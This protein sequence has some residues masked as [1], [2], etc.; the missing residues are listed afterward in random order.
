MIFWTHF[1]DLLAKIAALLVTVLLAIGV[2]S[3]FG[4]SPQIFAVGCALSALVIGIPLYIF[5]FRTLG[6]MIYC[7]QRLKA[8][9]TFDQAKQ[10]NFALA[11]AAQL[12]WCPLL[13]VRD[14]EVHQKFPEAL[15]LA[16][17][18]QQ[19]RKLFQTD[20]AEILSEQTGT[21]KLVR[22]TMLAIATVGFG[23]GYFAFPPTDRLAAFQASFGD[24]GKYSPMLNG[25]LV[26]ILPIIV[27]RIMDARKGI[28]ANHIT[29]KNG[30]QQ[31]DAANGS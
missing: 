24:D 6:T 12:I 17:N 15:R 27:V 3:L 10:L 30:G 13:A 5:V 18:W 14:V 4:P 31:I 19:E 26:A 7:R 21:Y 2:L 20:R 29:R 11:P 25:L 22:C 8:S 16:T 1:Y 9:F 23:A 28:H